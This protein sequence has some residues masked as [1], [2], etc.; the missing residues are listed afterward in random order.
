MTI[1]MDSNVFENIRQLGGLFFRKGDL[2]AK[3]F[4]LDWLK[5][6][7]HEINYQIIKAMVASYL[8]TIT[9]WVLSKLF[10][11]LLWKKRV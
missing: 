2:T 7:D 11:F 4:I 9:I 8:E 6:K 10:N 1:Y 3:E 5:G